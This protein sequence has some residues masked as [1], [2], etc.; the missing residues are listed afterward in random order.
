MK[1]KR[2]TSI[3]DSEPVK[4][5]GVG[6]MVSSRRRPPSF[7]LGVV[8]ALIGR[9][10]GFASLTMVVLLALVAV[11][12]PL[13]APYDPAAQQIGPRLSPPGPGYWMGTDNF[14]R[15]ILSRV[16]F[17]ARISLLVSVAAVTIGAVVGTVAGAMAGF[18]GRLVDGL[19]MRVVDVLFA[20]PPLLVGALVV[21]VYGPGTTSVAV[22]IA[23]VS[24]PVFA[25]LARGEVLRE[26]ELEYT[27]AAECL[28]A[29]PTRLLF[30]HI[31]R[32]SLG[33]LVAQFAI[34]IAFAVLLES[35]LSFIGFGIQPPAPSW[36]NML[37]ESRAYLR[38]MPWFGFFPGAALAVALVS[39]TFL[40]D[41]LRDAFDPRYRGLK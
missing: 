31:L 39:L 20:F 38:V 4:E 1:K 2:T 40:A 14:G 9:R 34:A 17:G 22:A 36:G 30:H 12:A 35:A 24:I 19:T 10:L 33:P 11:L 16:I 7:T 18:F 28:G 29:S 27:M 23:V 13:L 32:N 26:R 37:N 5:G 21:A 15:D 41:A 25:R 6:I 3:P 8:R